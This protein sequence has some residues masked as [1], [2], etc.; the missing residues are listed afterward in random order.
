MKNNLPLNQ[1]ELEARPRWAT[2]YFKN[3]PN[4]VLFESVDYWQ[5]LIRGELIADKSKQLY[6][7]D[8]DSILIKEVV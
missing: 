5:W 6:G 1:S 3:E 4:H 2:H 8:Q 7:I